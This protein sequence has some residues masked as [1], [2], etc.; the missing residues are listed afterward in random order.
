MWFKKKRIE[1]E[2]RLATLARRLDDA[3]S[4]VRMLKT[5]WLDTLDKLER[6]TGRLAKRA[7]RDAPAPVNGAEEPHQAP[8]PDVVALR[9]S[10]MVNPAGRR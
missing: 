6:L 8:M 4:Q 7:Q 10:R 2:D 1:E 5:E 9:R 3:E